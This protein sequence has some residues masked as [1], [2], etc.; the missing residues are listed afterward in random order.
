MMCH[1]CF[2]DIDECASDPCDNN[3]FCEDL[4]NG[5]KCSCKSGYTGVNCATGNLDNF[6]LIVGTH[7]EYENNLQETIDD[8][9]IRVGVECFIKLRNCVH[10]S[11]TY[12][13]SVV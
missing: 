3:G 1:I 4:T 13:E 9:N 7:N 5:F 11:M 12:I 8:Y 10:V 6:Q 2:P